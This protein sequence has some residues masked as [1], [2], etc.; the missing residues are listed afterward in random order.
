MTIS[1]CLVACWAAPQAFSQSLP[2]VVW[3]I[4]DDLGPELGCYGY[5]QVSTPNLDRLAAEGSRFTLA[6]ATAPVCSPSR[7]AF[8]TGQYQTTLGGHHHDTRVKPELPESAATVTGLMRNAGYF[9]CNGRGKADDNKRLAKSHFNFQYD[10][11]TFFDGHDWTQ[12]AEGQPFFA[13]VQIK[14]PHRTFVDRT[15]GFPDAPIPPYYPDHPVT[16]AD[17]ANYLSSIE[18]LDAKVGELLERLDAEG[19]A[20]NTLVIFFGDHGRPHVR[21]KQWLYD[22]G[23]HVP[24]LMRWPGKIRPGTVDERLVSLLDLMPTTLAAAAVAVPGQVKMVGGDLMDSS[25]DGHDRLFAARDRCGEAVDRIRSVRTRDFKYIRNFH[26]EIP[27]MQHSSYKRSQYPVDT[28]MRVLHAEGTWTSPLMAATRPPEELYDLVADPHEMNNLAED[29]A[30]REQL[31][32]MRVDLAN[33]IR[34]TDDKGRIDESLTVDLD[35]LRAEKWEWYTKTMRSRG[36]KPDLS[37]HEYLDW[38]V[39]ELGVAEPNEGPAS[40][41][42]SVSGKPKG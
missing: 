23:L 38:W 14:E 22:G 33:W 17:W 1:L 34:E 35:A 32:T 15:G 39:R 24:L 21:G 4:A 11:K 36:L 42:E 5:P 26:P 13:Q 25:W 6:F 2:N 27:Y 29:P 37:D 18:V 28:L 30:Y 31:E 19:L 40:A 3:I 10:S 8:Q 12:R 41:D 16:R 7:T 20:D 9:V